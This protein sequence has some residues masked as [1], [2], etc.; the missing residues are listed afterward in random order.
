M[1]MKECIER[2]VLYLYTFS[3]LASK[4]F[5]QR[6]VIIWL[7]FVL[8]ISASARHPSAV[9]S[10]PYASGDRI[11]RS[12]DDLCSGH[13]QDDLQTPRLILHGPSRAGG[14]FESKPEYQRVAHPRGSGWTLRA[15]SGLVARTNTLLL[16]ARAANSLAKHLAPR[17]PPFAS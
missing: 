7:L 9:A 2:A 5:G 4:N 16:R 10:S 17:A 12:C 13:L 6:P 8:I 3:M 1:R 14:V 11:A 15:I